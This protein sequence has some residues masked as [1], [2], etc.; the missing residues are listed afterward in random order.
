[1]TNDT[2][3]ALFAIPKVNNNGNIDYDLIYTAVGAGAVTM[4]LDIVTL[5][6]PVGATAPTF[7]VLENITDPVQVF[8]VLRESTGVVKIYD[9]FMLSLP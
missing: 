3:A 5:E 8:S 6:V 2:T 7:P 9:Y 1:L 4:D